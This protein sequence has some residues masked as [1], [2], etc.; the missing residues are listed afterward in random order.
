M[1]QKYIWQSPDWP[2]WRYD[3]A[4]LASLLEQ[5]VK[6]QG[7][8]YGRLADVGFDLRDQAML[9][10]LTEDIVKS[11]AIE[12]EVLSPSSVRSSIARRLGIEH[13][14]SAPSDRH[15][16]AMV[17]IMLDAT[18]RAVEPLTERR[19]FGWHA[20]LFP[21][22][23]SGLMPITVGKWRSDTHG[24]MQVV[25]GPSGSPHRQKVHY[26]APPAATLP[27][28]MQVFLDWVNS[29]NVQ[30]LPTE[31]GLLRAGIG[32]LWFVTLHPFDDGNGRIGRAIGDLLLARADNSKQRF[33]SLSA[34]IQSQ[35]KAYYDVL[36][37]TQKPLRE[38]AAM[39]ITP[40]LDWF[41][42]QML[43]ALD[44]AHATVDSVLV[45]AKFWQHWAGVS[46][47]PRQIKMLNRLLDGFDGKLT[48][49]R[50]GSMTMCSPDTALRDIRQLIDLGVMC[51]APG[52]GRAT[53]Y[54]LT[55]SHVA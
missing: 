47:N 9:E 29:V 21:S 53:S 39:D 33:Y 36:E 37:R 38:T 26:E 5:V 20:A 43:L 18:T 40:W 42:N 12:D 52:S 13:V 19:L 15:V 49:S 44:S 24:P 3:L 48:S 6:R 2:Q 32:H 1:A 50:W 34:Q 55:Q 28:Q 27:R 14:A 23:Y 54:V 10:T 7:C 11:S 25:S 17:D 30:P 41:L 31:P 45:K 51:R 8:L 22:G 35:R 16:D 4:D 46:L